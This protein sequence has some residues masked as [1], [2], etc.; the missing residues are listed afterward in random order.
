MGMSYLETKMAIL[1]YKIDELVSKKKQIDIRLM[2]L[3]EEREDVFTEYENLNNPVH[4]GE[5]KK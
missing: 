1:D 5:C 4:C 2:E 3:Y